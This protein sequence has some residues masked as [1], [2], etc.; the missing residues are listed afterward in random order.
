MKVRILLLV[1]AAALPLLCGAQDDDMYFVPKKKDVR[2]EKT[3]RP[4]PVPAVPAEEEATDDADVRDVDEY[5]RRYT[6]APYGTVRNDTLYLDEEEGAYDEEAEADDDAERWVNGFMGT[7]EDYACAKR[8]LR[9]RSPSLG[10]P[11]SSPLYWDLCYGPDAIYW[12]VYDDGAYAYVFPTYWNYG[13]YSG[14]PYG[15]WGYGYG[16]YWWGTGWWGPHYYGWYGWHSPFYDPWYVGWHHHHGP[17][18]GGRPGWGTIYRPHSSRRE[19]VRFPARGGVAATRPSGVPNTGGRTGTAARRSSG[20]YSTSRAG[21][22]VRQRGTT[23]TQRG[24][25]ST[26]RRA[27]TRT[28][29]RSRTSEPTYQRSVPQRSEGAG[30]LGGSRSGGSLSSPGGGFGG[31]SRGGGGGARSGGGRGGRR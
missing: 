27:T 9:F 21:Q 22:T 25:T 23:T 10:I 31:G 6:Y 14:W 2:Q 1:L 29:T 19:G 13:Y 12:N 5:N 18:W 8:L 28:T 7:D 30:Q 24:N 16:G 11:V 3:D 4:A 26:T 15:T 20:T 17:H